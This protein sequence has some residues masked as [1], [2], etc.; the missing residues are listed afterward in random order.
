MTRAHRV[1]LD[2]ERGHR[3]IRA[4]MTTHRSA[5]ANTL[6]PMCMSSDVMATFLARLR[7]RSFVILAYVRASS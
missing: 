6:T 3:L 5:S 1:E 2:D 4:S 7:V